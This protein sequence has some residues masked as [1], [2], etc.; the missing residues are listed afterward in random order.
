MK[1]LDQETFDHY[2]DSLEKLKK[3]SREFGL[4]QSLM[5]RLNS[6][7]TKYEE[8]TQNTVLEFYNLIEELIQLGN[9]KLKIS[10]NHLDTLHDNARK[11]S[12]KF[13]SLVPKKKT[14]P[15]G[16][17]PKIKKRNQEIIDKAYQLE[18][19][20]IKPGAIY[21]SLGKEH[22]LSWETIKKIIS[23]DS[24]TPTPLK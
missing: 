20:D 23:E 4:S 7:P 9:L 11:W 8:V 24:A 3:E 6:Q 18:K 2:L 14:K 19:K 1:K 17:S 16:Q 21:K 5:D 12:Q 15:I 13:A 10:E 22:N